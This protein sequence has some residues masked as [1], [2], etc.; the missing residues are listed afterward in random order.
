MI[1]FG[2]IVE[3]EA[4]PKLTTDPGVDDCEDS[5]DPHGSHS[6]QKGKQEE[7]KW[8]MFHIDHTECTE[9]YLKMGPQKYVDPV[10]WL[11]VQWYT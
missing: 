10:K 1:W 11:Q 5:E 3:A 7:Q 2:E 4:E 6:V 9:V 8:T